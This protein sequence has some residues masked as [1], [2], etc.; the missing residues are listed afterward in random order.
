MFYSYDVISLGDMSVNV[1]LELDKKELEI[2]QQKNEK[3]ICFNFADKIPVES[4]EKTIGGNACNV[5]V[6]ARRLG[7]KTALVTQIGQDEEAKMVAREL[8]KEKI[9]TKY[10]TQNKRTNFS[11]VINYSGERSIFIYHEPRTYTLPRLP[12][13][14]FLYLTSMNT[15]WEKLIEPLSQYLDKTGTKL[16]FNPGTFQLRAGIKQAQSILDRTEVIFLNLEEA[17]IYVNKPRTTKISELLTSVHR[18]GPRVVVI[19]DGPR[20]SYASDGTGQYFIG[21]YDVPVIERTGCGDAYGTGFI[22]A[23]CQGKD[24]LEAMRWGSFE[25][26]SVLQKIGPQAG[27]LTTKEFELTKRKY[28]DFNPKELTKY[29]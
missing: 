25:S 4:M 13:A 16:A 9:D 1:F 5:A 7:L 29:K 24:V 11:A 22:A 21:I 14:K 28:P 27:L 17:C 23:L 18:H 12:K 8:I 26:A 2:R 3:K 6:G 20:G 15:G 19:T 10:I